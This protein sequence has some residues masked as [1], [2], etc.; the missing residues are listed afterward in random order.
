M[1]ESKRACTGQDETSQINLRKSGPRLCVSIV[2]NYFASETIYRAHLL[3]FSWFIRTP[4]K[5]HKHYYTH[6]IIETLSNYN[7]PPL[8]PI[9]F[10]IYLLRL[11]PCTPGFLLLVIETIWVVRIQTESVRVGTTLHVLLSFWIYRDSLIITEA[12]IV[13][14]LFKQSF[15]FSSYLYR[16]DERRETFALPVC[17][18]CCC[19]RPHVC[20]DL[21]QDTARIPCKLIFFVNAFNKFRHSFSVGLMFDVEESWQISS[22]S[23]KSFIDISNDH[24]HQVRQTS[25]GIGGGSIG[26]GQKLSFGTGHVLNDLCASVWFSYLLVY[27]QYVLLVK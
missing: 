5:I 3:Y 2:Q 22:S 25:M 14:S 27:L 11:P 19:Y 4:I 17:L 24:G 7:S 13:P 26:W 8:S 16:V 9:H 23:F 1:W 15:P 10:F 6:T 20:I 18:L 12:L 21:K